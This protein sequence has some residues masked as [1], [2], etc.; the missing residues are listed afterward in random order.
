MLLGF[1]YSG[2]RIAKGVNQTTFQPIDPTN[3]F[4]PADAAVY[5]WWQINNLCQYQ[6]MKWEWIDPKGSV[7]RPGQKS[8]CQITILALVPFI[9]L[10]KNILVIAGVDIDGTPAVQDAELGR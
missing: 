7:L 5:S 1:E 4:S 8:L 10:M 2:N 3:S 6:N 9:R